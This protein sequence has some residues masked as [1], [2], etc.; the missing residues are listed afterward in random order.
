MFWGFISLTRLKKGIAGKLKGSPQMERAVLRILEME[1]NVMRSV[2][3]GKTG[4]IGAKV[5]KGQ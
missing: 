5:Q 3:P 4:A 1:I 2:T